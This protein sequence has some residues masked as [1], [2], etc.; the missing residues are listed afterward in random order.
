MGQSVLSPVK[1]ASPTSVP[2]VL[3]WN[4]I[5]VANARTISLNDT[6]VPAAGQTL[7]VNFG[8]PVFILPG[9]TFAYVKL[10]FNTP[11]GITS[12]YH[13]NLKPEERSGF[14]DGQIN[15]IEPDR[16]IR[17]GDDDTIYIQIALSKADSVPGHRFKVS[18]SGTGW[19]SAAGAII[20]VATG[21]VNSLPGTLPV[22]RLRRQ[23]AMGASVP[24]ADLDIPNTPITDTGF[25][26]NAASGVGV[27]E[28]HP[29]YTHTNNNEEAA[30]LNDYYQ[31]ENA[32]APQSVI[33][34]ADGNDYLRL[35][36]RRLA[37]P[38]TVGTK[39]KD[40]Q[41]SLVN[42]QHMPAFNH[43]TGVYAFVAKCSPELYFW[44]GVWLYALG[45]TGVSSGHS[46]IDVVE[47]FNKAYGA[48]YTPQTVSMTLHYG[49]PG[50]PT[51]SSAG[52]KKQL[53]EQGFNPALNVNTGFHEYAV[54]IEDDEIT[55]FMD[56]IEMHCVWNLTEMSDP[57]SLRKWFFLLDI[58]A[59]MTATQ[60]LTHSG[61]GDILIKSVKYYKDIAGWTM[62][63]VTETEPFADGVLTPN[64]VFPPEPDD[65][66]GLAAHFDAALPSHVK[67]VA[68]SV[69]NWAGRAQAANHA[70]QS[71]AADQPA[72]G[73]R[74]MNGL[75]ALKFATGDHL[76]ITN[77]IDRT[78]GYTAFAVVRFDSLGSNRPLWGSDT[79]GCTLRVD[80][81]GQ[82]DLVRTSQSVIL[83]SPNG[84]ISTNTT[85]LIAL[86]TSAAGSDIFVNGSPVG[87]NLTN[88]AY[89]QDINTIAA[90]GGTRLDGIIGEMPIYERILSDTEM[91]TVGNMLAPK[92]GLS[93]ANLGGSSGVF[94]PDVFETGVFQ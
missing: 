82:I 40:Y 57:A 87:S 50:G 16:F 15:I 3:P 52:G 20:E 72:T 67:A 73:T 29:P 19:L 47:T 79:G 78:N 75:N 65:V 80:T 89:T 63:D 76:D 34:D 81:N 14:T 61:S 66:P 36:S 51:V 31:P 41:G 37:A 53:D 59:N 54:V 18:I 38:V 70:T 32:I 48:N 26:G 49:P 28:G 9:A 90:S 46:E 42:S 56:R 58:T 60:L 68:G 8:Q 71:V 11:V 23:L 92:W 17:P 77:P 84:T 45:A 62:P 2:A 25:A 30:Y 5:A 22:Q 85:Y 27:L 33:Q 21:A 12:F 86:R 55:F 69:A 94:E 4:R 1:I 13:V 93:W 35:H 88:P 6:L 91:D 74:T 64:P 83:S 44:S 10:Q 7:G 24:F 43:R 39:S